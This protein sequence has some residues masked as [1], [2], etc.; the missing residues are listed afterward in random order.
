MKIRS[1]FIPLLVSMFAALV[2]L[3]ALLFWPASVLGLSAA[4]ALLY[5]V[6]VE[7]PRSEERDDFEEQSA[8]P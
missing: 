5:A 7:N 3:A 6:F 8:E 1:Y 2:L 4:M